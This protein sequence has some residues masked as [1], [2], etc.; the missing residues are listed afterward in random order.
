MATSVENVRFVLNLFKVEDREKLWT[1]TRSGGDGN[2]H[3]I[4]VYVDKIGP[5]NILWIECSG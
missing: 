5:Q 2:L 3:A 4:S 1:N